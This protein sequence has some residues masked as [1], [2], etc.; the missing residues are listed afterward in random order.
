LEEGQARE[1]QG[2]VWDYLVRHSLQ[3]KIFHSAPIAKPASTKAV[4]P[5]KSRGSK[6][7]V[8]GV[9]GEEGL[10]ENG[11]VQSSG[12]VVDV[13]SLNFVNKFPKIHHMNK[14]SEVRPCQDSY[15]CSFHALPLAEQLATV[16]MTFKTQGDDDDDDDSF[17]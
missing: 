8:V 11:S 6:K 9:A 13:K 5:K 10:E 2:K 14:C 1:I 4:Q 12:S 17:V 15:W 3:Y 16:F 7:T